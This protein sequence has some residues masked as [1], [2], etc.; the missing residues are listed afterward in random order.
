MW[1]IIFFVPQT[2]FTASKLKVFDVLNSSKGLTLEEVAARINASVLGTERLLD[3]AVSLG[4][5]E[6]V[7]QQDESN[8]KPVKVINIFLLIIFLFKSV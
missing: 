6:R 1:G 8:G 2:L 5:L 3:A 4:L 7:K